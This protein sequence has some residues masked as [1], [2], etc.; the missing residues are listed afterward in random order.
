MLALC[1]EFAAEPDKALPEWVPLIPAGTFTGRDGR[2]WHNSNPDAV[3]AAF[4]AN[5][6]DIVWDINHSTELKAPKGEPSPA[7]GFTDQLENRDGTIWAHIALNE[8]GAQLISGRKYRYYSP[9]FKFDDSNNV[10]AISSVALAN[11]HNLFELPALNHQ[12]EDTTMPIPAALLLALGLTADADEATAVAKANQLTT[13]LNAEKPD[14]TQYVPRADYDQ[15]VQLALNAEQ[16]LQQIKDD[17]FKAKAEAV[18]D[19][20]IEDGKVAPASRDYHLACC[21]DQTGLDNFQAYIS[22]AA[23]MIPDSDLDSKTPGAAQTALNAEEQEVCAL[24]DMT[25]EE[26]LAAKTA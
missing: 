6:R 14:L 22:K 5:K 10:I 18:V 2:R 19:K 7:M 1:F 3:V 24:L 13:A 17:A 16:E 9:A 26:Y 23:V 25:E 8:E 20:A 21:S 12:K 11:K 4:N 15:K